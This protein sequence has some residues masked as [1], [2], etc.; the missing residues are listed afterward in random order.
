MMVK[1]HVPL[2]Q[3]SH[4]QKEHRC[5]C[6]DCMGSSMQT[7]KTWLPDWPKRMALKQTLNAWFKLDKTEAKFVHVCKLFSCMLRLCIVGAVLATGFLVLVTSSSMKVLR[8]STSGWISDETCFFFTGEEYGFTYELGR[9]E[10]SIGN[11]T[12][13]GLTSEHILLDFATASSKSESTS[14]SDHFTLEYYAQFFVAVG[15]AMFFVG[16]AVVRVV[17]SVY[18]KDKGLDSFTSGLKQLWNM[19]LLTL[20]AGYLAF[21]MGSLWTL[22][23]PADKIVLVRTPPDY[24]TA[25]VYTLFFVTPCLCCLP[26]WTLCREQKGGPLAHCMLM[27][28]LLMAIPILAIVVHG[29]YSMTMFYLDFSFSVSVDFSFVVFGMIAKAFLWAVFVIDTITCVVESVQ[30]CCWGKDKIQQKVD[31]LGKASDRQWPPHHC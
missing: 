13:C 31:Q 29:Y 19:L 28:S 21:P 30:K 6:A 1:K 24:A 18:Q 11:E 3:A 23:E 14:F 16:V 26:I 12:F 20:L 2:W 27:T 8:R 10:V 5:V 22:P 9:L 17:N 4:I 25:Q 15:Y 7:A